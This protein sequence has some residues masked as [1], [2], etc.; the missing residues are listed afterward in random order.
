M[1]LTAG[2]VALTVTTVINHFPAQLLQI[3]GAQHAVP[4][5]V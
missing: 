3:I 4:F 5:C 2:S 1:D